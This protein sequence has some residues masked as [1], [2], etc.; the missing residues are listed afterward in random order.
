[1]RSQVLTLGIALVAAVLFDA[2]GM[3]LPFLFGPMTACLIGALIGLRLQ[4]IRMMTN[5]ARAVL[6]VA[7]GA[8]IT[9]EVA[10]QVP[11]MLLSLAFVPLYIAVCGLVGYPYFHRV[12]GFDRATSFYAAMP[13]GLQDMTLFGTAAGGKTRTISLIHASRM[14][15]LVALVPFL[16]VHLLGTSLDG[17]AQGSASPA[18]LS[19]VVLM[20]VAGA[21]GWA[22]ARAIGLNGAPI[23]GPMIVAAILSLA[24]LLEHRP[25]GAFMLGAQYFIGIGIAVSYVGVT[26]L[27]LRRDVAAGLGFSVMLA[28]LAALPALVV[29]ATGAAP[30][31]DALLAFSPGGQAEML[32]IALVVGAD[33]GYVVVHHLA[34]FVIVIAMAPLA[35]RLLGIRQ[36]SD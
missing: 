31:L 22:G 24:G 36:Q 33:L 21:A 17:A 26:L 14:L 32:L 8:S 29:A 4:A 35:A 2:I 20:V 6:G 27:E 5:V 10:S 23:L 19:A 13:G 16:L 9:P 12:F 7:V 30:P 15:L 3:P 34:R 25:A 28:M 1:M 18:P 11:G